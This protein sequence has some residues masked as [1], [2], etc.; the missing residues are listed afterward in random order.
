MVSMF[1]NMAIYNT[2]KLEECSFF[3]KRTLIS[4]NPLQ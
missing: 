4:R 2:Q 1:C 3:T